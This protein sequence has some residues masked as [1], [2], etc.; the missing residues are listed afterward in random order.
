MGSDFALNVK[1][2]NTIKKMSKWSHSLSS[3][4]RKA[5]NNKFDQVYACNVKYCNVKH[6]REFS[7][8]AFVKRIL[9]QIDAFAFSRVKIFVI[10]IEMKQSNNEYLRQFEILHR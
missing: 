7:F 1:C 5:A 2:I 6:K 9:A 4:N 8:I 10:E 3:G